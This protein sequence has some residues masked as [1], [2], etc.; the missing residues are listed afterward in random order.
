MKP[1]SSTH[2]LFLSK[3]EIFHAPLNLESVYGGGPTKSSDL[4]DLSETGSEIFVLGNTEAMPWKRIPSTRN[5]FHRQTE[6]RCSL[7]TFRPVHFSR[8]LEWSPC[9]N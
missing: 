5:D 4:Y 3:Q 2:R 6:D 7:L 9:E 8:K 1:D